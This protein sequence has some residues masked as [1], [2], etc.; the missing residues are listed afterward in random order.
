[1]VLNIL[2]IVARFEILS[3][4]QLV[5]HSSGIFNGKRF[6]EF[7]FNVHITTFCLN[8]TYGKHMNIN[9]K[10]K[11]SFFKQVIFIG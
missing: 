2:T 5:Q 3:Q 1:M 4:H 6:R 8:M 11:K 9:F 10:L 7:I